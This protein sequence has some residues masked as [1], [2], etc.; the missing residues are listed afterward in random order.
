MGRSV[1]YA[2]NATA[3]AYIAQDEVEGDF[4]QEAWDDFKED[5]TNILTDKFPSLKHCKHWEG[6]EVLFFLENG[7]CKIALSEYCGLVSVSLVP[8]DGDYTNENLAN[9][10]CKKIKHSFHKVINEGYSNSL[11]KLGTFS[12][13]EGVYELV[14]KQT[15]VAG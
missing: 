10:Y 6:N 2:R 15:G 5:L 3:V 8:Q 9:A 12:N 1:N 11:I 14:K 7:L 13:G 4:T